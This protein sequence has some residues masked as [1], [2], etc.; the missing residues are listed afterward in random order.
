MRV[1]LT[2]LSQP[3]SGRPARLRY[4]DGEPI[5]ASASR[6]GCRCQSS[7]GGSPIEVEESRKER[8]DSQHQRETVPDGKAPAEPVKPE[9]P[10]TTSLFDMPAVEQPMA[11]LPLAAVVES[12]GGDEDEILDE[13]RQDNA[14]EEDDVEHDKAA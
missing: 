2:R 13:I 14:Q 10:R 6:D 8:D 5:R 12:E 3:Q 11:T 7:E 4:I 9:P 1:P